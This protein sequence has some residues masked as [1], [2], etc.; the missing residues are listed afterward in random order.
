[1]LRAPQTKTTISHSVWVMKMKSTENSKRTGFNAHYTK[2]LQ[3][4]I[5][6]PLCCH[7]QQHFAQKNRLTLHG[8]L[9]GLGHVRSVF[10]YV[11]TNTKNV[12][13]REPHSI[14]I[15]ISTVAWTL[16]STEANTFKHARKCSWMK[17]LHMTST[18]EGKV[19][20]CSEWA[21]VT[22]EISVHETFLETNTSAIDYDRPKS[23]TN[24]NVLFTTLHT[25]LHLVLGEGLFISDVKRVSE[26]GKRNFKRERQ[27]VSVA[28]QI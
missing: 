18:R 5:K 25:Y 10:Y 1:M 28:W 23:S 21:T 3:S 8:Y 15:E 2:T 11:E 9:F 19:F 13:V 22:T 27:K 12:F 24:E 7:W 16:L 14:I 26:Y 6:N 20:A 4:K 17:M